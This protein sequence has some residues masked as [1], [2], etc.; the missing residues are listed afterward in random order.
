M[1]VGKERRT[2]KV[3]PGFLCPLVIE[4]AVKRR[5]L[6]RNRLPSRKGTR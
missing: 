4:K 5:R 6:L 1:T 2:G 3:G